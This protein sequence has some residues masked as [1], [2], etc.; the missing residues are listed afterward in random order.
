M[1]KDGRLIDRELR[2][3]AWTERDLAV[4]PKG[5]ASKLRLAV[6]LRAETAMTVSSIAKRLNMS[7]RAH[8]ANPLHLRKKGTLRL[9]VGA[10]AQPLRRSA[11]S[12]PVRGAA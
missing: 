9:P 4:R 6:K 10:N 3:K 2:A 7:S 12:H 1:G 5:D 11:S 8:L